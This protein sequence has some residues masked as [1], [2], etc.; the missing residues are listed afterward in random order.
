MGET[1]RASG[2]VLTAAALCAGAGIALAL[3][4]CASDND[5]DQPT[6]SVDVTMFETE[7]TEVDCSA[8]PSW[9]FGLAR[10]GTA[11]AMVPDTP[12]FAEVCR[13]DKPGGEQTPPLPPLAASGRIDGADLAAVV[14][15]F[16][17]GA[18]PANPRRCGGPSIGD[19]ETLVWTTF[20]YADGPTVRVGWSGPC[21]QSSNGTRT[22]E[23]L[24]S[25]IPPYWT[26]PEWP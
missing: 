21:N 10:P 1:T 11:E 19:P 23:G 14:A 9:E 16:N 6:K 2:R 24:A 17:A 18:S 5:D 15:A 4:G 3:T 22:A 7:T 8:G 12:L 20:H 13:Y 26:N 25:E